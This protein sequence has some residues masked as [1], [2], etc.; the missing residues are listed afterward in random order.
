[1]D[2]QDARLDSDQARYVDANSSPFRIQM[3]S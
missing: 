1:M 2:L 3:N